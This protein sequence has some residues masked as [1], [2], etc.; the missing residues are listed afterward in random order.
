MRADWVW[1]RM[2]C[3]HRIIE[4][5]YPQI[6]RAMLGGAP[7]FLGFLVYEAIYRYPLDTLV[8][9]RVN[10]TNLDQ[11]SANWGRGPVEPVGKIDTPS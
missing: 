9:F 2:G 1:P 6:C 4:E 8:F 7:Q 5:V 3:T 11:K 10:K